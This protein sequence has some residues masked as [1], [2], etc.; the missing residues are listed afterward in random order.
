MN[1]IKK[2]HKTKIIK[3]IK[4]D[5]IEQIKKEKPEVIIIEEIETQKEEE[6]MNIEIYKNE[7]NTSIIGF[8]N[9]ENKSLIGKFKKVFERV[10]NMSIFGVD[11]KIDFLKNN[12]MFDDIELIQF[13]SNYS[14]GIYIFF[15]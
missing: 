4:K 6:I 7:I 1:E 9:S 3:K 2:N 8:I 12:L 5:T 13:I 15:K 14:N 10:I 11:Q